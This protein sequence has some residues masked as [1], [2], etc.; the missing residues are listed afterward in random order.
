M[1]DK[2]VIDRSSLVIIL[3]SNNIAGVKYKVIK[4]K[5]SQN[6]LWSGRKI[7][8]EERNCTFDFSYK[9][10]KIFLRIATKCYMY[11]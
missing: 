4:A 9:Y 2:C 5:R 6:N 7:C 3:L 1:I 11:M 10:L 8:C